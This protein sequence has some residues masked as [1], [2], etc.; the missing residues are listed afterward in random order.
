[1]MIDDVHQGVHT[2]P[3]RKR[4]GRGI[5]SGHGKTSGRGHKG[6]SS[7][8]GY[9]RHFGRA[10][11]QM[12]I[13]RRVAKRGFNNAQFQI[14]I[15]EVNVSALDA[16]F[17]AGTVV[18]PELMAEKGLAKGR[19]EVVKILGFGEITKGL[20]VSA[21]RF[22]ASAEQKIVAAGGKI[23]RLPEGPAPVGPAA[24]E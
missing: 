3:N 15:A 17:A 9:R 16:A 8:S 5:G 10:G 14:A 13:M 23:E 22:S 12:P 11:G 21:H 7:R 19:F 2:Q 24:A 20:T 6:A 1:M 18:T 4:V